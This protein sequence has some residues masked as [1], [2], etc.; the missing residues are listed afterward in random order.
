M[1]KRFEIE[2]ALIT[3]GADGLG[4]AIGARLAAEGAMVV[5]ADKDEAKLATTVAELKGMSMNVTGLPMDI[6]DADAVAKLY[7]QVAGRFGHLDMM[8]NAAGIV[9]TTNTPIEDN[10]PAAFDD[11]SR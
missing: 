3:G 10:P 1:K 6:A 4:K 2:V 11:I 9:G 7:D 5:L 8:I